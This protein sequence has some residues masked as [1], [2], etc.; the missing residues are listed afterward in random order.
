MLV[1]RRLVDHW[2]RRWRAWRF[3]RPS[4]RDAPGGGG[5]PPPGEIS[6]P[7]SAR[8]VASIIIPVH[9]NEGATLRCLGSLSLA[10]VSRPFEVLVVDDGSP[11]GS[12]DALGA[13][14]GIGL[15]RSVQNRG[16]VAA[17]NLGARHAGAPWLV[18]LNNDTVVT[19]GWL[20]RLVETVA[21]RPGVGAVGARLLF[22]DGRL[23]EAGGIVRSDGS[24]HNVGRGDHPDAPQYRYLRAVDYCSGA[25]LLVPADVFA[26]LG[27]FDDAYSPAYYEDV[28]LAFKLRSV[29]LDV[30]Y[31]PRAVVFHAE[32]ATAG[33]DPSQGAKR[34]QALHRKVLA[35]RWAADL[36]D[37]AAPGTDPRS[38]QDRGVVGRCLV[39]D[40]E[41]PRPSRDAGSRRMFHL[42]EALVELGWKVVFSTPEPISAEEERVDLLGGIGVECL[43]RPFVRSLASHLRRRGGEY[44]VVLL[45]RPAVAAR[46]LQRIRHRCRRALVVYDTVDL[47]WRRLEGRDRQAGS[48]PSREARRSREL[49]LGLVR[50]ADRVTV[51]SP[52]EEGV[53]Q[54]ECPGARIVRV[55]TYYAPS[56]AVPAWEERAGLLFVGGFRHAPNRDAARWLLEEVLPLVRRELGP[57]PVQLVGEEPPSELL[58]LADPGAFTGAVD[59]LEP[60]WRR[61]RVSV[62]PLRWGAG[63]K[64]KVHESLARGVP[65]VVTRVAAEGFDAVADR[66][67]LIGEDAAGLARAVVSVYRD[68]NRWQRISE[69]GLAR[70]REGYGWRSF[71]EAVLEAVSGSEGS[72][73]PLRRVRNEAR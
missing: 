50:R 65:C 70:V 69:A 39:V 49:E 73:S 23:Q 45:S 6:F 62:A 25:C 44:D 10:R 14:D 61:A 13:V 54:G 34:Y 64:G 15:V 43:C 26:R 24:A 72:G 3:S 48:R 19:D 12:L 17:C 35:D 5:V 28:D 66:E 33:R 22:E 42:L 63:L 53:L 41:A 20:D 30:L 38:A 11:P 58:G 7:A 47:R 67:L 9:G 60:Y 56:D 71:R 29:D 1:E 52:V 46:W 4:L 16:F 8:P 51:T 55:P 37:Q 59:D 21:A 40:Q 2:A 57:I 18:F 32:G 27:G 68:R 36:S 31:Q